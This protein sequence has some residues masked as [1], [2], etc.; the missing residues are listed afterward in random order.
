MLKKGKHG[1]EYSRCLDNFQN[2]LST[3]DI[4][5]QIALEC[6]MFRRNLNKVKQKISFWT[7]PKESGCSGPGGRPAPGPIRR[8]C[9]RSRPTCCH[10]DFI[11]HCWQLLRY[12]KHLNGPLHF[13]TLGYSLLFWQRFADRAAD[14]AIIVSE[15]FFV[16]APTICVILRHF[17]STQH[18]SPTNRGMLHRANCRRRITNAA[19]TVIVTVR[20]LTT[21]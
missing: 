12:N 6:T 5:S 20:F 17:C 10:R 11:T 19:V 1:S 3:H 18:T 2:C 14:V 8:L 15:S 4:K 21:V 16:S 7:T 13:V 9:V